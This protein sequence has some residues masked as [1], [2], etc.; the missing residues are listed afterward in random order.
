MPR[1]LFVKFKKMKKLF[2]CLIACFFAGTTC[3]AIRESDLSQSEVAVSYGFFPYSDFKETPNDQIWENFV[4]GNFDESKEMKGTTTGSFNIMFNHRFNHTWGLGIDFSYAGEKSKWEEHNLR[5]ADKNVFYLT[6]M[7]RLKANWVHH[8][9]F[10]IYSSFAAGAMWK[11]TKGETHYENLEDAADFIG[12]V[13]TRIAN[14]AIF[15][16]QVSP[17]GVEVGNHIGAFAEVGF[18]QMGIVQAGLRFRW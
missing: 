1:F 15:S 6:I 7:P 16:F 17:L 3:F 13:K 8:K 14:E 12:R 18:G 2:L 10:V 11:R 9:Y 4:H 5:V